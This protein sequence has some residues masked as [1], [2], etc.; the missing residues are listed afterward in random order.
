[1]DLVEEKKYFVGSV[2]GAIEKFK[3]DIDEEMFLRMEEERESPRYICTIEKGT[4]LK[5]NC[6]DFLKYLWDE[7]SILESMSLE[8][9]LSRMSKEERL[10]YD[11]HRVLERTNIELNLQQ[12]LH[13][14]ILLSQLPSDESF[15]YIS[16]GNAGRKV[17]ITSHSDIPGNVFIILEGTAK[18]QIE[19]RKGSSAKLSYKSS[20]G[21]NI[22]VKVKTLPLLI[23][24]AGTILYLESGF[25]EKC[26]IDNLSNQKSDGFK[27]PDNFRNDNQLF[28]SFDTTTR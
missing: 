21:S 9:I 8:T 26:M 17:E 16:I 22:S 12:F 18:L 7:Q 25:I 24:E 19:K 1:M 3:L 15:N 28:I 10:I 13:K 2:F 23:M 27:Y 4:L 6:K 20:D 14:H 11:T 5:L